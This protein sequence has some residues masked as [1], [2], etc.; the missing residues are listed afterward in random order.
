M[1]FAPNKSDAVS[2][3]GEQLRNVNMLHEDF[4]NGMA[5]QSGRSWAEWLEGMLNA[6]PGDDAYDM[7]QVVNMLREE[8]AEPEPASEEF[9]VSSET[10]ELI[11]NIWKDFEFP[12]QDED[13][14]IIA[15]TIGTVVQKYRM[16]M[17]SQI[18]GNLLHIATELE[19]KFL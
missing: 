14:Q 15:K 10:T 4:Y 7:L 19:M 11:E 9:L 5:R 1:N 3:V 12:M 16:N 2:Y 17:D 8:C 6:E 18:A 13:Y